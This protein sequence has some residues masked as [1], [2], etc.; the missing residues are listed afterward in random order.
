MEKKGE[1][2]IEWPGTKGEALSQ[3]AI[4]ITLDLC[5]KPE[6]KQEWLGVLAK[7]SG[8]GGKGAH[9]RTEKG[10]KKKELGQWHRMCSLS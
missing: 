2:S 10:K 9:L 5:E 1:K 7:Q 8:V 4:G 3:K 6:S